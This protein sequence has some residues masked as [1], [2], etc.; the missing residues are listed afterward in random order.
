MSTKRRC[1]RTM[2]GPKKHF[3]R[4]QTFFTGQSSKI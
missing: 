2:P 4:M 3:L 1:S